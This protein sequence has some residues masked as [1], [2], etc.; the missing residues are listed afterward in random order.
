LKATCDSP[1]VEVSADNENNLVVVK[2]QA[3]GSAKVLIQRGSVRGVLRVFMKDWAGKIL[4]SVHREVAGDP[5][6]PDIQI[7]AALTAVNDAISLQPGAQAFLRDNPRITIPL[8]RGEERIVSV[9]VSIEGK[10]Y[11]SLEGT[12]RVQLKNSGLAYQEPTILMISNRPEE[13]KEDGI[14]FQG[15]FDRK[16]PV[17]LYYSHKNGSP[18]KRRLWITFRN[19]SRKPAKIL[20]M[21]AYAGPDKYEVMAG[22]KA[23]MRY[24]EYRGA[25]A[26]YVL[27]MKGM[28]RYIFDDFDMSPNFTL[29]GI[30]DLQFLEGDEC[31]IE[32]KTAEKE[33]DSS[34]LN[35]LQEPFDPFKIHPHG[36]FPSP[37]IEQQKTLTLPGESVAF[38]VGK[39]PWLI[40]ATTGEPNT[41]NYGAVYSLKV[42][43]INKTG[44]EAHLAMT[45]T[46]LNGTSLGS[47]LVNGKLYETGVVKPPDSARVTEVILMPG[48]ERILE[49]TT[50]PEAGSCYPVSIKFS[51][52]SF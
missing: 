18:S 35:I 3:A 17:R 40:D 31:E 26:G 16:N 10:G 4:P 45:F 12:V 44:K 27:E 20:V 37:F 34:S 43:L 49:I 11:F 29:S 33:N 8:A 42:A 1:A 38:E 22:H 39:W 13:L 7:Q 50:L 15:R 9:P 36:I 46:P 5:T 30:C 6:P 51:P 25:Q 2:A 48:E 23:A 32:I 21:K 14:L 52:I 24:L 41:G 28:S 47:F 19:L